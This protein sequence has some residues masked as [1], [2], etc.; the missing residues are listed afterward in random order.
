MGLAEES[1]FFNANKVLLFL[2]V[3]SQLDWRLRTADHVIEVGTPYHQGDVVHASTALGLALHCLCMSVR[4]TGG[5][6]DPCGRPLVTSIGSPPC[7]PTVVKTRL[8]RMKCLLY[9]F[10]IHVTLS[11]GGK[12]ELF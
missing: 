4:S 3:C 2:F 10:W 12:L 8:S 5:M 1:N 7:S 6:G 11:R 9:H